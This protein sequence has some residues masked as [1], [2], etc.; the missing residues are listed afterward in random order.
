MTVSF[1]TLDTCFCYGYCGCA[2]SHLPTVVMIC[3]YSS[4]TLTHI[5]CGDSN[6]TCP[7]TTVSKNGTIFT[8]GEFQWPSWLSDLRD[9]FLF[10]GPTLILSLW[11]WWILGCLGALKILHMIITGEVKV[12]EPVMIALAVAEKILR[13]IF[14]E[15]CPRMFHACGNCC[16]KCTRCC[17]GTSLCLLTAGKSRKEEAVVRRVGAGW[18]IPRACNGMCKGAKLARKNHRKL[19]R[20]NKRKGMKRETPWY[21]KRYKCTCKVK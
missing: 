16:E 17:V 4:I 10:L 20:M 6:T 3:T 19:M 2:V 12:P 21:Q 5:Q 9:F 1:E 7:E 11:I 15:W 13:K 14:Q 18:R 8:Q